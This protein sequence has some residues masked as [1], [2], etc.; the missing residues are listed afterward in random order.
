MIGFDYVT[1]L[2]KAFAAVWVKERFSGMFHWL[3]C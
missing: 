1:I 3:C 2:F